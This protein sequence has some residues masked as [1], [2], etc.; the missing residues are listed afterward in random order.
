MSASAPLKGVHIAVTRARAQAEELAA[1][2]RQQGAEVLIAPLIRIDASIDRPAVRSALDNLNRYQWL[3][4]TSVNGVELFVEALRAAS[5]SVSDLFDVRVACVG[6]AT[7]KAATERGLKV[8]LVPDEFAGD[9]LA[10]RLASEVGAGARV[11]LARAGGAREQLPQRL[12]EH[13][14]KVDEI[15]LYRSVPDA[16]GAQLLRERLLAGQID[17]ITFTSGSTVRYF[18][19]AINQLARARV[20]VIGPATAEA[21]RRHNV[22]VDLEASPHTT[23]GLIDAIVEY[24]R[25]PT[26]LTED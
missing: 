22:R 14:A 7:A 26:R 15:E 25:R 18:A 4:L 6:P 11:L 19:E 12:T 13:G 24:Y 17:L 9:A 21:A 8:E 3:V 1:P 23:Q 20:A 5:R 10:A 16:D 2:L